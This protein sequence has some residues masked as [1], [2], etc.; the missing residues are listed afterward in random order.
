MNSSDMLLLL[1]S[2]IESNDEIEMKV[3][4]FF[5]SGTRE[6]NWPINGEEKRV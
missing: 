6:R 4:F 3:N 2:T 5:A 1:L